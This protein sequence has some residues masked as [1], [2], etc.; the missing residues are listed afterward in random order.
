MG[1]LS[2]GPGA[3][4]F[5]RTEETDDRT[6][7]R[8]GHVHRP[9][10]VGDH[11]HAAAEPFHHAGQRELSGEVDAAS[12]RGRGD[13]ASERTVGIAAEDDDAERRVLGGQPGRER[14]EVLGRPTFVGPARPGLEGDPPETVVGPERPDRG[15]GAFIARHPL[16]IPGHG[17]I[18]PAQ[19]GKVPIDRM[20]V[21]AGA[22]DAHVVGDRSCFA[23]VVEADGEGA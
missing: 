5:G 3:G 16:E 22:R 21:V 1:D 12:R 4:R 19:D 14:R 13:L 9:G 2:I 7:Q 10:V 20:D 23:R 11:H 6:S 8:D 17:D 15:R 18:E